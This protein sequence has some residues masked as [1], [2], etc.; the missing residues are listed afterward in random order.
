MID[1]LFAIRAQKSHWSTSALRRRGISPEEID[2]S[3]PA[4]SFRAWLA[5]NI[6][7]TPALR[8]LVD[9]EADLSTFEVNE[10]VVRTCM[11]G[12]VRWHRYHDAAAVLVGLERDA[13]TTAPPPVVRHQ[14]APR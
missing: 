8:L 4:R 9:E 5:A 6:E 11:E 12:L 14:N 3:E 1:R 2:D 7:A 10:H 13:A